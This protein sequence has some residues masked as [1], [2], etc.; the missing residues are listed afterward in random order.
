MKERFKSMQGLMYSEPPLFT[1]CDDIQTFGKD[2][3]KTFHK[4]FLM[5]LSVQKTL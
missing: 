5:L 1:E 4:L 2:R 3:M